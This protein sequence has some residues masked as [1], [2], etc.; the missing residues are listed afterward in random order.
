MKLP[1]YQVHPQHR[2]RHP[3]KSQWS[4]SESEEEGLFKSSFSNGW[5]HPEDNEKC[6]GIISNNRKLRILGVS[7][8]HK[9][10]VQNLHFARFTCDQCLWHGHPFGNGS[11]DLKQIPK[12]VLDNWKERDYISN[13]VRNKIHKGRYPL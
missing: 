12:V 2:N 5:L 6:F 7:A 13:A 11:S 3:E 8:A 4:I 9:P 1:K 10:P